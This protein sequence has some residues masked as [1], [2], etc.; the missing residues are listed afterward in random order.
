M[1]TNN[2]IIGLFLTCAVMLGCAST[3][4]A[5]GARE[6]REAIDYDKEPLTA[7]LEL[8][9]KA[10]MLI[11][12][13]NWGG[14]TLNY[15]GKTYK[16]KIKG[17]SVGGMGFH[18]IDAVGKIYRLKSLEDFNGR[19]NVGGIGATV[20]KGRVRST[21]ENAKGVIIR[22]RQKSTGLA[23]SVGLASI[24]LELEK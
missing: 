2:K 24:T 7:T 4:L 5:E 14:G 23:L 1:K 15:Q 11:L 20:V 16:I 18:S 19:Y 3:A 12:G 21:L 10:I 17:I 8:K 13:G 22:L 9:N 6:E